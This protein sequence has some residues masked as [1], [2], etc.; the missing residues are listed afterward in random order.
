MTGHPREN[1]TLMELVKWR[2]ERQPDQTA[3]VFL[4]DG[5]AEET[6]NYSQLLRKATSI[7]TK[8]QAV[9]GAS[10]CALLLYRPGIELIGAF[11]GCLCGGIVPILLPPPRPVR[12][13][14]TLPRLVGIVKDAKPTIARTTS[15]GLHIAGNIFRQTEGMKELRL[16]A[17]DNIPDDLAVSFAPMNQSAESTAF[18]QYT[19]GSTRQPKGVMI[20]HGN[21]MHN[22]GAISHCFG[23][24][25]SSKGV[26]WLPPYHD[27]GL[28]GGIL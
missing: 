19:S 14:S 4:P 6:I 16:I 9:N 25:R 28:I 15:P 11:L 20:S 26:M 2:A 5:D 27:M 18:L 22:L 1:S 13:E 3:F 21:L 10:D 24:S 12:V 23:L 7:A 17:T 8:L